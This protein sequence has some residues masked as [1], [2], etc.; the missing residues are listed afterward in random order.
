LSVAFAA[1]N[2]I[3]TFLSR[4]EPA[5]GKILTHRGELTFPNNYFAS[6]QDT[7][8]NVIGFVWAEGA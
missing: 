6:V 2:D 1:G 8:G 4:V 5:G 3:E 7:E